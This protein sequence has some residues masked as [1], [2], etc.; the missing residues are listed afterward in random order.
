M[1][2]TTVSTSRESAPPRKPIGRPLNGFDKLSE[3][4]IIRL[5]PGQAAQLR[6]EARAAGF[7]AVSDFVRY[8]K[9]R[10]DPRL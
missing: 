2:A 10:V 3:K 4:L 9:L 8:H 1:T 7:R 5:T 6:E